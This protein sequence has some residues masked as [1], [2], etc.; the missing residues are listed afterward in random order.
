MFIKGQIKRDSGFI[1]VSVDFRNS[2]NDQVGVRDGLDFVDVVVVH[3]LVH[4]RVQGVQE[5]DHLHGAASLGHDAEVDDRAE[6]G[7]QNF[8]H[9]LPTMN[10]GCQTNLFFKNQKLKNNSF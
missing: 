2:G 5:L 7:A 6:K 1:L 9:E 10:L 8:A 3:P 4:D